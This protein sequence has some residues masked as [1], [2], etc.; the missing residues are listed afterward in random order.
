MVSKCLQDEGRCLTLGG[1][2]SVAIG[3]ITGHAQVNPDLCVLWV[4]AH[5]DI[6]TPLTSGSGNLHGMP[7]AFLVKE[8]APYVPK[9]PGFENIKPWYLSCPSL[10]LYLSFHHLI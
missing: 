8:L 6:N 4:D 2:H 5:A 9:L 10:S 3:T 7:L 1:D